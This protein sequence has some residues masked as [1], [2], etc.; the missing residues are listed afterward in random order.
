M[1]TTRLDR[2]IAFWIPILLIAGLGLLLL[3]LLIGRVAH[4]DPV[5]AGQWQPAASPDVL[6]LEGRI[7]A[8]TVAIYAVA[9][10]VLEILKAIAPRTSTTVDDQVRDAL[11]AILAARPPGRA[12]LGALLGTVTAGLAIGALVGM[13]AVALAGCASVERGAAAGKKAGIE[14]GKQSAPTWAGALARW[15]VESAIAREFDLEAL[16]TT[17]K[18]LALGAASCFYGEV[19]RA[20]KAK[21]PVGIA[22]LAGEPDVVTQIHALLVKVSGGATVRLA[23]GTEVQ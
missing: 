4:A 9:R 21:Q 6:G 1:I 2:H 18:G 23:D 5:A 10:T 20:W 8:W 22:A 16:K 17:G 14:C 11:A 15:G 3:S 13:I 7:A 19:F 12:R